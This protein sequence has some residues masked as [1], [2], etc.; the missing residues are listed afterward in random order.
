M[1]SSLTAHNH[2][3]NKRDAVVNGLE[4]VNAL[5]RQTYD[6]VLMD[7]QMPIMDGLTA[8]QHIRQMPDRDPWIIGLSANAFKELRELLYL[9]A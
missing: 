2:L 6:L 5:K 1:A 4:G 8:C 3:N 9:R 7:I